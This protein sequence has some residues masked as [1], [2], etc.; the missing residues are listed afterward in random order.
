MRDDASITAAAAKKTKAAPP[1][2]V[3]PGKLL[4]AILWALGLPEDADVEDTFRDVRAAI[5]RRGAGW[6]KLQLLSGPYSLSAV[7]RYDAIE[8]IDPDN[9]RV[10]IRTRHLL[11][12]R[13]HPD[14]PAELCAYAE[15]FGRVYDDFGQPD[16]RRAE[17][18]LDRPGITLPSHLRDAGPVLSPFALATGLGMRFERDVT[19]EKA[20]AILHKLEGT[21]PRFVISRDGIESEARASQQRRTPKRVTADPPLP[22]RLTNPEAVAAA[23]RSSAQPDLDPKL[24]PHHATVEEYDACIEAL[25]KERLPNAPPLNFPTVWKAAPAWLLRNCNAKAFYKIMR[26]RFYSSQHAGKRGKRGQH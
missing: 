19:Q 4:D 20:A 2:W 10:L 8:E 16:L 17:V 21:R 11:S 25:H 1:A 3:R 18:A 24:P 14:Y 12:V 7:Q 23:L 15:P 6:I 5:R 22:V 13:S 9:G 26:V